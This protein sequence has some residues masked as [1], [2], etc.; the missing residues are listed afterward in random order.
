DAGQLLRGRRLADLVHVDA[1]T[2]AGRR[3]MWRVDDQP[4]IARVDPIDDRRRWVAL[5]SFA[6]LAY[7]RRVDAVAL[8]HV[9]G[10]RRREDLEPEVG[11]TL[12]R[13]DH[14]P[15]VGVRDRDEHLAADGQTV[16]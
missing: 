4:D 12:D 7:D 13:E 10:T 5:D 6:Q 9:G 14:V 8:Q 1:R 16:L 11:Q 3:T 15:L 2:A